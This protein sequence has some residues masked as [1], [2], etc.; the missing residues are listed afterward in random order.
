MELNSGWGVHLDN[1]LSITIQMKFYFALIQILACW[2]QQNI[3]CDIT[4]LL[5]WYVQKFVVIW[6]PVFELQQYKFFIKFDW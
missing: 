5:S 3:A 2:L 6:W 1:G 4:T